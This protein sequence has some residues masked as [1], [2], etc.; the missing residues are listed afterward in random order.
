MLRAGRWFERSFFEWRKG[1]VDA[2]LIRVADS[3]MVHGLLF[4]GEGINV[5]ITNIRNV[6]HRL[7]SLVLF[8][9]Q[10][11]RRARFTQ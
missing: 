2:I 6:Q 10:Q 9:I 8:H 7:P 11:L 3:C 1:R 4:M 5:W